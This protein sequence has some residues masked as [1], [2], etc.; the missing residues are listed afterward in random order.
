MSSFLFL[1]VCIVLVLSLHYVSHQNQ[2]T[3]GTTDIWTALLLSRL[4]ILF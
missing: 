2:T 4:P 1:Y 3:H